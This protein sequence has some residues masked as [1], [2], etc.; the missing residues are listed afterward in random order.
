MAGSDKWSADTITRFLEEY[1]KH[2]CLWDSSNEYHKNRDARITAEREILKELNMENVDVKVF[3]N[4]IKNIRN[5]YRLEVQKVNTNKKSEHGREVF[6]TTKLTWFPLADQFLK[7]TL[8]YRDTHPSLRS[9]VSY[10]YDL[11]SDISGSFIAKCKHCGKEMKGSSKA[12]S[13]LLNHI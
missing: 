11:P 6:Y 5:T 7:K 9:S 12:T 2:P 4:K 3:R 1:M 13:N 10:H 8:E